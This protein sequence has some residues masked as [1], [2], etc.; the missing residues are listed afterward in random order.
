MNSP[1]T[2]IIEIVGGAGACIVIK[3]M[4]SITNNEISVPS[5][6]STIEI[7]CVD[8]FINSSC[9]VRL[10]A[11]YIPPDNIKDEA[12][13]ELII[14]ALEH[15]SNTNLPMCIMGDLNLPLMDWINNSS[16]DNIHSKFL[17]FF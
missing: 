7:M 10:I 1:S 4:P 2:E 13:C 16:S 8:L 3:N 5:A 17:T 6:F 15:L 9:G 11:L 12:R 14:A